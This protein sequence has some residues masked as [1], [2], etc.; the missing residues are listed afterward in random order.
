MAAAVR[1]VTLAGRGHP[2]Y[3]NRKSGR[4][5]IDRLEELGSSGPSA[6]IKK[7]PCG[8]FLIIQFTY[9]GLVHVPEPEARTDHQ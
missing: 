2:A 9:C 8:P 5:A 7:G 3:F 1:H 6:D 4:T